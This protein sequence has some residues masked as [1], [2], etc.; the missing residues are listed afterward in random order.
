MV[1][2]AGV[3]C[4]QQPD[5]AAIAEQ[6]TASANS[7]ADPNAQAEAARRLLSA[8]ESGQRDAARELFELWKGLPPEWRV[9]M[10]GVFAEHPQGF[11]IMIQLY[12]LAGDGAIVTLA[13]SLPKLEDA[14]KKRGPEL[15]LLAQAAIEGAAPEVRT[16]AEKTL[17]AVMGQGS[18]E[19]ARALFG[20][21]PDEYGTVVGQ[22]ANAARQG[23][24]AAGQVLALAARDPDPEI[25]TKAAEWLG[26]NAATDASAL[27][28]IA[29]MATDQDPNI[30]QSAAYA[31]NAVSSR[32]PELQ[33]ILLAAAK[34]PDVHVRQTAV[35][36]L[37]ADAIRRNTAATDALI[38]ATKDADDITRTKAVEG[39]GNAIAAGN[40]QARSF[41][42]TLAASR[43]PVLAP[44]A[45]AYLKRYPLRK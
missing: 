44:K 36:G 8:V 19:F 24:R 30:R 35:I 33:K 22:V 7:A 43:D 41:M 9:P 18:A 5:G 13:E 26:A 28:A 37:A 11:G 45:Q 27:E 31:L 21:Q 34:D 23:N 6:G 25:R 15:K 16:A 2:A 12:H 3:A 17:A 20:A 29:A 4:G 42:K 38:A 39:L 10:L 1:I 14:A 40:D 32:R